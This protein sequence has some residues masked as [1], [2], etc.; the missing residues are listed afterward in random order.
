MSIRTP[1]GAQ[2]VAAARRHRRTGLWQ[3][4]QQRG[5]HRPGS[6]PGT[7]SPG[8][9][10]RSVGSPSRGPLAFTLALSKILLHRLKGFDEF[11]RSTIPIG[12]TE[13]DDGSGSEH[14]LLAERVDRLGRNRRLRIRAASRGTTAASPT[15]N[16]ARKRRR[17]IE[18]SVVAQCRPAL[19]RFGGPCLARCGGLAL[20]ELHAS[21]HEFA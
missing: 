7:R 12:Y 13:V 1:G 16:E 4:R 9:V 11:V 15:T 21:I 19:H 6:R 5:L 20:H 10:D 8:V 2:L 14:D 3:D 17:S 18:L